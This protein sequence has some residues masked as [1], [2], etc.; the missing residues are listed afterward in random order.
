MF[1][2][3]QLVM[4]KVY[5]F[6]VVAMMFAACTNDDRL[7][8]G[9]EVQTPEQNQALAVG[10]DAYTQR[11]VTRAG[12]PG[13]LVTSGA[14]AGQI[15]LEDKGFGVFGYYTDLNEYDQLY[16][17]NFMY[18]Q[19]VSTSSWSYEPVKYWPNEYGNAAI[20]DDTDKMSFFAYAPHVD[21]TAT[22]GKVDANENTWG[23]TG[24]TKNSA[25]GD[26]VIKYVSAFDPANTI[27]L[28]WG[29]VGTA[30]DGTWAKVNGGTQTLAVGL[31]WINV[32]RP[33]ATDQKMKFTFMHA[34][35][36]LFVDIDA[37]VDALTPGTAVASRTKI[38][39]RS[40][41]FTGI[42]QKGALN[43]NNTT[44]GR[45]LWLNY[46]GTD[47]LDSGDAV[48]IHD[49]LKDGKEGTG[50]VAANEKSTGLNP[51]I[52]SNSGNTT[53]G[54][55]ATPTNL[56][57]TTSGTTFVIPSGEGMTVTIVY[58]VET[59]DANLAGY[60]S[61]G[62]THGSSIQNVITKEVYFGD[63]NYLENGKKYTLH[64]HLGMN[65]VKFDAA[66]TD[67]ENTPVDRDV[68]LPFNALSFA[69]G[70]SGKLSIDA[71][72]GT[73]EYY[74]TGMDKAGTATAVSTDGVVVT[75]NAMTDDTDL[76]TNGFAQFTATVAANA[77]TKNQ[78]GEI[79]VS[80]GTTQTT[81]AVSQE[82]AALG[83]TP[84]PLND[85]DTSIDI[86]SN[87][88]GTVADWSDSSISITKNGTALASP[89]DYSFAAGVVTLVAPAA[90]A[91]V[92]KIT[93]QVEDAGAE[94]QE[95][96]VP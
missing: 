8:A 35:A 95:I 67:W 51:N 69:C 93:V 33:A 90:S 43:L 64:L 57:A 20:S 82:A 45:A 4:R 48:T 6:A 28:C 10:F 92:Y 79:K 14:V 22:S 39:V 26:P 36:Q 42:A 44:P 55:I 11:G 88:T 27:D 56:F 29:V 63:V 12:S 75:A 49:G 68:E 5:L 74:I 17:P 61:D 3:K 58:D 21:V 91:D 83:W 47:E 18:N 9:P 32:E 76:A 96:T 23:I 25:T 30:G 60:L 81:I 72:G 84:A 7:E 34:L 65:S 85:T 94:T 13:V 24:M 86:A 40:I 16:T 77:A 71:A 62:V 78:T 87:V 19:K 15:N 89:A 52:I 2:Q 41:S 80:D 70:A 53:P 59:E 46:N 38:Y 1:N 54:V 31:P 66:V 73:I 37:A 50:Q